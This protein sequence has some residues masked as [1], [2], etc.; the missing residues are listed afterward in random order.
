MVIVDD[1]DAVRTLMCAL[2]AADARFD[3]VAEGDDGNV[4]LELAER[5]RPDLM[6]LDLSMP[7]MGGLEALPLVL[8]RSPQTRVFVLSGYA[9][10]EFAAQAASL[11]ASGFLEKRLPFTSVVE[12]LAAQ[13]GLPA[14]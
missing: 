12:G 7:V 9:S 8:A 4:A 1:S 3:V 2:F 11:G 14:E 5:H 6:L 13:L 10:D